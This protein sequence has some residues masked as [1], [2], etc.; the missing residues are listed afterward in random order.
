MLFGPFVI[1]Q[2]AVVIVRSRSYVGTSC[3]QFSGNVFVLFVLVLF[4][5]FSLVLSVLFF[6]VLSVLILFFPCFV[7][8]IVRKEGLLEEGVPGVLL[9]GKG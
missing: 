8:G 7:S 3:F 5:L 6:L 9:H 4:V 2:V 1:A